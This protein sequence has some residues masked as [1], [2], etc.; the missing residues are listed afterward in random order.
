MKSKTLQYILIILTITALPGSYFYHQSR[1]AMTVNKSGL[2]SVKLNTAGLTS[3]KINASQANKLTSGLIGYWTF[4]GQDTSWTSATAGT[5]ADKSPVGTNTG[6]FANMSQSTSP[7][8][9]KVGQGM[10]F[11]GSDDYVT[12]PNSTSLNTI[13]GTDKISI[14]MWVKYNPGYTPYEGILFRG[15][16]WEFRRQGETN[17]TWW[18]KIEGTWPKGGGVNTI[19]TNQ[20][21]HIVGT[22]NG[23][24]MIVY[25]DGNNGTVVSTVSGN[26]SATTASLFLGSEG[27][28]NFFDGSIDEVRVYNRALSQS[29]IT[30]LYNL[31]N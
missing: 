18:L 22:Y 2:T 7:A 9:G 26:I 17:L 23:S 6:T 25:V 16:T 15:Y 12:I 19:T 29:E 27:S 11:D 14:A 21:H 20:W 1:A 3:V 5:T 24:Q 30:E 13:N 31:G 10:Y 4:D 28:S 8:I